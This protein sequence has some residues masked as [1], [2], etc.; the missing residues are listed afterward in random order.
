[1]SR[2]QRDYEGSGCLV[3][4]IVVVALAIVDW[5]G[6]HP[7]ALLP[8]AVVLLVA[9]VFVAWLRKRARLQAEEYVGSWL[10]RG[11]QRSGAASRPCSTR[12]GF[13]TKST[14]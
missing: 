4:L 9:I 6:K 3:A 8:I 1:L 14:T 7:L 12:I 2:R 13:G 11:K 10:G 5:F